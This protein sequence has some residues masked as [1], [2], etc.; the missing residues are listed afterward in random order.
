LFPDESL[1]LLIIKSEWGITACD[2]L[3]YILSLANQLKSKTKQKAYKNCEMSCLSA[4]TVAAES[5]CLTRR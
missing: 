4:L 2:P 3:R 1:G 5:V